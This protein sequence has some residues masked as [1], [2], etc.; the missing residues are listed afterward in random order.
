MRDRLL[1]IMPDIEARV[2]AINNLPKI[3]KAYTSVPKF[4]KTLQSATL[5]IA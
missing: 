3:A 1:E 4:S 5:A 2:D